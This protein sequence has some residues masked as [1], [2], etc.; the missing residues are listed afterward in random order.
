MELIDFE[1][2]SN[3]LFA[4]VVRL[5]IQEMNCL[6]EHIPIFCR[7]YTNTLLIKSL[8]KSLKF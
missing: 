6:D 1:K 8:Y 3:L 2:R 4:Y 5:S 7:D